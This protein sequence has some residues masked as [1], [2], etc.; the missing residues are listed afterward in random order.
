[1]STEATVEL[2]LG[3]ELG[4]GPLW[5]AA[6][7]TLYWVDITGK[8]LY[9]YHPASGRNEAYPLG[10]RVGTVA[11][12]RSGGVLVALDNG[13]A[14]YDLARRELTLLADPEA[15]LPQTRFNDGKVGP[16]GRFWAGT[17][18]E[19]E[20]RGDEGSLYYLDVD[21][22]VDKVLAG[23][24]I[25]NGLAWSLDEKTLY[26]VDSMTFSVQAF[27]YDAAA[28]TLANG[29][30]V[31]TVAEELGTPD[32]MTIDEEGMLWVAHWGGW[33][34][35]RWNP[36]TGAL[37]ASIA[38]PVAQVTACTFGGPAL[39]VLYIT[40]AGGWLSAEQQA[41]QPLAGALF[42]VVPGVRG[43]PAYRFAG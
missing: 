13:F 22:S 9:R 6:E 18:L 5:D 36:H 41:A 7:Q 28:G 2:N 31:I 40:T 26:F 24:G 37:L 15:H 35:R 30:R 1:M 12:R 38:L 11:L 39:D 17:M 21:L 25:S 32:G 8:T 20:R 4:E 34:V 19:G 33:A 27:D 23:I 14:A 10:R 3:A 42:S 29:R 43:L 16:D